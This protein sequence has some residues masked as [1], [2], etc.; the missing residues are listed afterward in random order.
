MSIDQH[1]MFK[2]SLIKK[3][4]DDTHHRIEYRLTEEIRLPESIEIPKWLVEHLG[5]VF[6]LEHKADKGFDKAKAMRFIRNVMPGLG[7]KEAKDV[8]ESIHE[9]EFPWMDM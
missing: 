2:A 6:T 5:Y 7:L 1:T 4:G 8:A 9:F 3:D